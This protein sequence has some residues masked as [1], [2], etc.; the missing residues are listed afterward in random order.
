MEMASGTVACHD[1][2]QRLSLA[3]LRS[4]TPDYDQHAEDLKMG[5]THYYAVDQWSSPEWQSAWP[6]LIQDAIKIIDAADVPVSGPASDTLEAGREVP[7]P[8]VVDVNEGLCING[9]NDEY[10]EDFVLKESDPDNFCKTAKR[11]YDLVVSCILLRAY[12]LAPNTF[13]LR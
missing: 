13:H 10:C 2:N 6:Q 1:G 12:R 11:G 9:N 4:L 8:P 7:N 3:S 5:Y